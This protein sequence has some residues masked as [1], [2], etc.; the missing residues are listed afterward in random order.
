MKWILFILMHICL[1]AKDSI[2]LLQSG[3]LIVGELIQL[4]K[5]IARIKAGPQVLKIPLYLFTPK[6][7]EHLHYQAD[8]IVPVE[9][10]LP[11]IYGS[12]FPVIPD[13]STLRTTK[14]ASVIPTLIL[15]DPTH[16]LLE[17]IRQISLKDEKLANDLTYVRKFFMGSATPVNDLEIIKNQYKV[18][19][20]CA[21]VVQGN[22]PADVF[23]A[24]ISPKAVL[25]LLKSHQLIQK[26]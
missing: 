14:T 16:Q 6:A 23:S 21:L 4:E 2:Y 10:L 3:D 9:E 8:R 7:R 15:I 19:L 18:E 24:L 5:G 17:G 25:D 22:K 12:N 1:L 20:P 13:F 26:K 11:G